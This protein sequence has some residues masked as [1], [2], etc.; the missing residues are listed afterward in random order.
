MR[1]PWKRGKRPPPTP[2]RSEAKQARERAEGQLEE[3]RKDTPEVLRIARALKAQREENHF[4][5]MILKA[6]REER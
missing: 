4:S 3:A 5:P 2:K 6:L 1:W